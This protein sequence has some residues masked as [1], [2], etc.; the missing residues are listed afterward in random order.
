MDTPSPR[1]Y[2]N[3]SKWLIILILFLA[4]RSAVSQNN[5]NRIAAFPQGDHAWNQYLY[6][7][8]DADIP[9]INGAKKGEYMVTVQFTIGKDGL[10][11]DEKANTHFGFGMEEQIINAIKNS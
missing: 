4:A 7:N 8:I 6:K 5:V 3:M 1:I 11:S 9:Q 10:I 2:N